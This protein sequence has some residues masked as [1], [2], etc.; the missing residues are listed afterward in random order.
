MIKLKSL[1]HEHIINEAPAKTIKKYMLLIWDAKGGARPNLL[2]AFT[3][4][5]EANLDIPKG[6]LADMISK[7]M[8]DIDPDDFETE[9][10]G[11]DDFMDEYGSPRNPNQININKIQVEEI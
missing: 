1:L 2:M 3:S 10:I 5:K 8:M 4:D 6:E 9:M 7:V 11:T